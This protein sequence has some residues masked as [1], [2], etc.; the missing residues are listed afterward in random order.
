MSDRAFNTTL[1]VFPDMYAQTLYDA[2]KGGVCVDPDWIELESTRVNAPHAE[3]EY[4]SINI[5]IAVKGSGQTNLA[6]QTFPPIDAN[7][8]VAEATVSTAP[9]VISLL[10][11]T[12]KLCIPEAVFTTRYLF[13]PDTEMYHF[14][15]PPVISEEFMI[16]EDTLTVSMLDPAWS[17]VIVLVPSANNPYCILPLFIVEMFALKGYDFTERVKAPVPEV[18]DKE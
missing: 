11:S 9:Q 6:A 3:T 12:G 1:A 16:E 15:D 5:S 10:A 8:I 4:I 17:N 13:H 14:L 2:L 18:V 7:G